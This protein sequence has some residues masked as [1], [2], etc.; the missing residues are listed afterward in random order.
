MRFGTFTVQSIGPSS[1]AGDAVGHF[2][3]QAL[4]AEAAGFYEVWLAEHN[5]RRY[6]MVGNVAVPLA[7]LAAAT[8]KVRIGS[9][10]TRLPLHHPVHLCEDLS[11]VDILSRGR[12]DWGIGRGYDAYEFAAYGI[13][14]EEAAERWEANYEAIKHMW[15]TGRTEYQDKFHS[16][17]DSE[18]LPTPL[19]RPVLPTYVTVA[20]SDSSVKWCAERLLPVIFGTGLGP[21]DARKKLELYAKS[22]LEFSHSI[23]A[24]E[25]A[26]AKTW[27]LKQV[28]VGSTTQRAIDEFRD[29]VVWYMEALNNRT[30]F[31]F[32]GDRQPYEYYIEHQA[33]IIGSSQKVIETLGEYNEVSGINNVI[34]WMNIGEQPHAQVLNSIAQFGEEVIPELRTC[35]APVGSLL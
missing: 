2:F 6:G 16:F 3:D 9:A 14:F 20:G 15:T 5:G 24:I 11:Y 17:G 29:G 23:D 7:A 27:Q 10:V 18:L 4:A 19:Q 1:N 35:K 12:L 26:L 22:A 32:S 21:E 33:V 30:A 8:S 31:G 13:P 25:E 28:H 34:C